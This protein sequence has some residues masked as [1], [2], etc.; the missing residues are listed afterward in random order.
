LGRLL[1]A[2]VSKL[3]VIA[4]VAG[5]AVFC[6]VGPAYAA[7]SAGSQYGPPPVPAGVPGGFMAV[8][9]SVT[10]GPAGGTIGPVTVDGA[11]LMVTIPAGAFPGPVQISVTAPDLSAIT[12]PAGFTNV[13]GFGIQ[14]GMNGAPY[15]G[16]FLKPIT[17]TVSSPGITATSA[18]LVW[19]GTAFVPETTATEAAGTATVSFDTDPQFVVATPITVVPKKV[20]S[21]VTPVTGEPFLGEG[22]LAGGLL[23][24]GSGG[25]V[26]ALRRRRNPA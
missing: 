26:F 14:V 21:A 4:A 6:A 23:V 25:L 12:P 2:N 7:T 9:T 20:P 3:S 24:L 18:V 10:I 19:N 13:T 5:M 16:T 17:A 22:V 1:K 11:S 8:V 15:P